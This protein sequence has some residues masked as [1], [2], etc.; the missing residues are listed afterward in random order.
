MYKNCSEASDF[1]PVSVLS[2]L[3]Q[4]HTVTHQDRLDYIV[5]LVINE[6]KCSKRSPSR[7]VLQHSPVRQ[8]SMRQNSV[9]RILKKKQKMEKWREMDSQ[10]DNN[11]EKLQL[12]IQFDVSSASSASEYGVT[13]SGARALDRVDRVTVDEDVGE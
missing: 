10:F 2:R 12:A 7:L 6:Q 9:H 11:L 1:S 13:D 3:S 5:G 4:G 8:H